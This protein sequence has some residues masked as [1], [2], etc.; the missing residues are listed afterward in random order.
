MTPETEYTLSVFVV[1]MFL[2]ATRPNSNWLTFL[3]A[4]TCWLVADWT[5]FNVATIFLVIG[6]IIESFN[7]F[8]ED[9]P[10]A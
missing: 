5:A 9:E 4:A 2:V 7:Q 6:L 3:Y 8:F 10:T 1:C